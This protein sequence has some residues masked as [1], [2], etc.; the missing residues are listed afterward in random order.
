MFCVFDYFGGEYYFVNWFESIVD[1]SK[2]FFVVLRFGMNL[3]LF[4]YCGLILQLSFEEVD[5]FLNGF[6]ENSFLVQNGFFLGG[7]KYMV[8]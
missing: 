2:M 5:K 3:V 7:F 6:E 1:C 4:N 8:L